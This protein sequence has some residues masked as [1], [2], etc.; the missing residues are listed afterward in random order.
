MMR[1]LSRFILLTLLGWR[2]KGTFEPIDQCVVIAA[3]HTS[4]WDFPL[5]LFTRKI[6]G[7]EINYI[8]KKSLFKP[9]WGWFFRWTGGAPVERDH[10][11]DAVASIVALFG[12]KKVFRLAM[13]PEGTRKKVARWRT[14]FYHIALAAQVPLLMIAMDYGKKEVRISKPIKLVGQQETDFAMIEDFFR[15]AQGKIPEYTSLN[16]Q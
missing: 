11:S 1:T 8:G 13:A 16:I 6:I 4:N 15:G 2:I 14:G 9:L 10:K 12:Q 3:P 5:G 7:L